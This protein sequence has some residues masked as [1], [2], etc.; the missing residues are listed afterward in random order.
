MKTL[1]LLLM[2]IG[3]ALLTGL[4]VWRG[5]G[6]IGDQLLGAG[7]QL[8]WLPVYFVVPLAF[9]T[10][11]WLQLFAPGQRPDMRSTMQANW[12]GIAVNT[13]LPAAQIGGE[14][15]RSRLIH[16]AGVAGTPAIATVIVDKT[17]QALTQPLFALVGLCIF[18]VLGGSQDVIVVSLFFICLLGAGIYGFYVFQ[19]AGIFGGVARFISRPGWLKVAGDL[20]ARAELIDI[21]I[22]ETYDRRARFNMSCLWRLVFRLSLVVEIWMA[23]KFLGHPIGFLDALILESLTQVV[24]AAAFAI[25]GALGVQ[26]GGFMLLGAAMGISPEFALSLSLARR[27]RELLVGIPGIVM[28]QWL[29]GRGLLAAKAAAADGAGDS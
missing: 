11:A 6:V 1:S 22:R 14:L 12:I 3:L 21:E 27:V 23:A 17:I 16:K 10:V 25:P 7:W 2:L 20:S 18:T 28:W 19:R 24:V 5:V 29:E 8:L 4:V 9:G 13:I 26:E 15:V